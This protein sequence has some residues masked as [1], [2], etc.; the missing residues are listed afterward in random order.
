MNSSHNVTSLL[1]WNDL[2][3]SKGLKRSTF[4]EKIENGIPN[5]YQSRNI[6]KIN[7]AVVGDHNVGKTKLINYWLSLTSETLVWMVDNSEKF[8]QNYKSDTNIYNKIVWIN[9]EPV[10]LSVLEISDNA[11]MNRSPIR[12]IF[13]A[14]VYVYE[15]ENAKSKDMI[16]TWTNYFKYCISPLTYQII[17]G[18]SNKPNEELESDS[19]EVT[20]IKKFYEQ[21]KITYNRISLQPTIEL[22]DI[23]SMIT[24]RAV[25]VEKDISLSDN[26]YHIST[27]ND[28]LYHKRNGNSWCCALL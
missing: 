7:I 22:T 20:E 15:L 28:F 24:N 18:V 19:D 3:T 9:D 27:D 8:S 13:H 5:F 17:L 21:Y 6:S 11:A 2:K 25:G 12:K 1:T 23:F 16:P 14:I 26:S 10:H 4:S